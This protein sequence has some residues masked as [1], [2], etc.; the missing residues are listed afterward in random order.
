MDGRIVGLE[1]A[2]SDIDDPPGFTGT[3]GA[4]AIFESDAA[5]AVKRVC[6]HG[7]DIRPA[8]IGALC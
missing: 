5:A 6:R 1:V 7:L 8:I 3:G 4:L 2:G